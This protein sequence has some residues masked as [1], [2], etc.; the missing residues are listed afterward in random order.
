MP[1]SPGARDL[2]DRLCGGGGALPCSLSC[3]FSKNK[4]MVFCF[5]STYIAFLHPEKIGRSQNNSPL[6]LLVI[7]NEKI[8]V[9][10]LTRHQVH[11]NA[12]WLLNDIIGSNNYSCYETRVVRD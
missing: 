2:E 7:L 12:H 1:L 4:P 3:E 10:Y 8:R 11:I 9:K 6:G 5:N